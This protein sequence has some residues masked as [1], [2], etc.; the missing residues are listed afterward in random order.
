MNGMVAVVRAC[1]SVFDSRML[2]QLNS[3]S[4]IFYMV[5]SILVIGA[6][7]AL[8]RRV[9]QAPGA[10]RARSTLQ[11]RQEQKSPEPHAAQGI[12][13]STSRSYTRCWKVR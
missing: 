13:R 3:R 9:V 4:V 6:W 5:L 2:A 11:C 10:G 12:E 7:S 1:S 8:S